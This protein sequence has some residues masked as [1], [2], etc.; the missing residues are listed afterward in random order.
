MLRELVLIT[1]T[2]V[3]Y[4]EPI[5]LIDGVLGLDCSKAWKES[6]VK[7]IAKCLTNQNQAAHKVPKHQNGS[8]K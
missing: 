4:M 1:I 2:F 3:D 7:G 8:L 5:D 6:E